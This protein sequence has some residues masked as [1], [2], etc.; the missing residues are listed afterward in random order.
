MGDLVA[1]R[2][3]ISE[4][5]PVVVAFSGGADSSFLA[6]V[7]NEVLGNDGALGVTA[8]S[9]SLAPSELADCRSLANEW[10]FNYREVLSEEG[11]RLGY[12][13]N[14][15]DRCWYCKDEL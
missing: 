9:P 13:A 14:G 11:A 5:G 12:L 2:S 7:A 4:L 8:V 1:L 10:A 3:H 6:W 15:A